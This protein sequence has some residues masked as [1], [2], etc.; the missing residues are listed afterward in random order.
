MVILPS[1]IILTTLTKKPKRY[2]SGHLGNT[3]QR[4]TEL[5]R[6]VVTK[7]PLRVQFLRTFGG[8]GGEEQ[9]TSALLSKKGEGRE[10]SIESQQKFD[11]FCY[12]IMP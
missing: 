10:G 6:T 8:R 11:F 9:E 2:R 4:C 3:N 1:F 5:R 12:D 7:A